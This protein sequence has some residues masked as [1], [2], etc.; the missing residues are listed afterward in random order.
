MENESESQPSPNRIALKAYNF[1]VLNL[2]TWVEAR[3]ATSVDAV[4]VV[5]RIGEVL[6]PLGVVGPCDEALCSEAVCTDVDKTSEGAE[7]EG[8]EEV[9]QNFLPCSLPPQFLDSKFFPQRGKID[10]L[11]NLV[12]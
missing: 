1:L 6:H 3:E 11:V 9:P 8:N 4:V 5:C 7:D 2:R 12:S 10:P